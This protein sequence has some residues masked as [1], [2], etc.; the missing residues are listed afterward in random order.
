MVIPLSEVTKEGIIAGGISKVEK[1]GLASML[2]TASNVNGSISKY[3]LSKNGLWRAVIDIGIT[4]AL[5]VGG[6]MEVEAIPLIA[7][8]AVLCAVGEYYKNKYLS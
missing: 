7:T 4:G 1:A 6:F 2:L 3:G 5:I 8:G